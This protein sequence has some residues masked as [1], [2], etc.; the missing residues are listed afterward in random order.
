M[1]YSGQCA[2]RMRNGGVLLSLVSTIAHMLKVFFYVVLL[3]ED[4]SHVFV[5]KYASPATH[6]SKLST[7]PKCL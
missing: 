7:D 6:L 3:K 4:I 5:I 2:V 1:P